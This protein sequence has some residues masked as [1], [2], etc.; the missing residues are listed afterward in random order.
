MKEIF[1]WRIP[2]ELLGQVNGKIECLSQSVGK[3]E[4]AENHNKPNEHPK[5]NVKL[6]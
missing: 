2:M 4:T 5:N 3:Q 1:Q 6:R